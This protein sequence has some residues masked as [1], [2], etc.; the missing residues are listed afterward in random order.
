MLYRVTSHNR[1][2]LLL[3]LLLSS[4]LLSILLLLCVISIYRHVPRGTTY[5]HYPAIVYIMLPVLLVSRVDCSASGRRSF[6]K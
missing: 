3:L 6:V 5:T 1:T 2:L 4:L